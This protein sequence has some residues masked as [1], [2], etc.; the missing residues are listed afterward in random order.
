MHLFNT[1]G[2]RAIIPAAAREQHRSRS[3]RSQ[4]ASVFMMAWNATNENTQPPAVRHAPGPVDGIVADDILAA[5]GLVP[6]GPK[7]TPS[8]L[9]TNRRPRPAWII[10][11]W[12]C[13]Y[14]ESA[15]ENET[16]NVTDQMHTE[17]AHIHGRRQA[18]WMI[19]GETLYLE[20]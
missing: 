18:A 17:V 9:S 11:R 8:L 16:A 7:P 2:W 4:A 13:C 3:L 14:E 10:A 15:A 20:C 5:L 19:S 12:E 1:A 6:G